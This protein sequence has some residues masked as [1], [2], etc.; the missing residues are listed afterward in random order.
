MNSLSFSIII[1]AY[2]SE[3]YIGECLD[4]LIAQTYA[5]Y[6]IICVDDGSNDN[7]AEIIKDYSTKYEKIRY[8]YQKNSGPGAARNKGIDSAEGDYIIF[9][10]SDD[11]VREDLLEKC[12]NI[13]DS[14]SPDMVNYDIV[15]QKED[16]WEYKVFNKKTYSKECLLGEDCFLYLFNSNSFTTNCAYKKSFL[17]DNNIRFLNT[18]IYEDNDFFIK[19]CLR[20]RSIYY[21][22]YPLYFYR[23]RDDSLTKDT[24]SI[25]HYEQRIK[26]LKSCIDIYYAA[27]GYEQYEYEMMERMYARFM[28]TYHKMYKAGSSNEDKKRFISE[29]ITLMKGVKLRSL[30]EKQKK[31]GF[32]YLYS[33]KAFRWNRKIFFKRYVDK[34]TKSKIEKNEK[35][36]ND[37]KILYYKNEMAEGLYKEAIFF[38]DNGNSYSKNSCLILEDIKRKYS[39]DEIYYV[40]ENKFMPN[41]NDKRIE[42]SSERYYQLMARCH[43]VISIGYTIGENLKKREGQKWINIWHGTDIKRIFFDSEKTFYPKKKYKEI[44]QKYTDIQKWD[45]LI[46]DN[47][48]SSEKLRSALGISKEKIKVSDT[49]KTNYLVENKDNS[50]LTDSIRK[51]LKLGNERII[52]YCPTWRDYNYKK[53][54]NY[55]Y[56]MD[57][58]SELY[59]QIEIDD[60]VKNKLDTGYKIWFYEHPHLASGKYKDVNDIITDMTIPIEDALLVSDLVISDY[61]SVIADALLIHKPVYLYTK[62]KDAYKKARGVYEDYPLFD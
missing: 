35:K 38:I 27:E 52:L 20:S 61:S 32:G 23:H 5:S 7:T 36:L 31:K 56:L 22:H 44:T 14:H 59:D 46:V 50:E 15:T 21:I 45:E 39:D 43:T 42:R 26:S 10:D 9:I 6:E 3:K 51:K 60:I 47:K 54:K 37:P 8:Y 11:Y 48:F 18:Y 41:D 62:D 19:C 57:L 24:V 29:Y 55:E 28:N 40:S 4:S 33:K 53:T 16:Y 1:P 12:S 58:D 30:K 49:P 34:E 13:I 25:D 17:D 2:N